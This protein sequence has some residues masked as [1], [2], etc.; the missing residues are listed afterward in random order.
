MLF[1]ALYRAFI[2]VS[3]SFA[4]NNEIPKVI[5]HVVE[6][7]NAEKAREKLEK[8][9]KEGKLAHVIGERD[10]YIWEIIEE[11]KI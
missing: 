1:L 8:E 11:D 4:D 9:I 2:D 7:S 10:Y 5:E 3:N 6:A